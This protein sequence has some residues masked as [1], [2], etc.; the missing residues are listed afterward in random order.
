MRRLSNCSTIGWL[1]KILNSNFDVFD[2]GLL[3]IFQN[4]VI[5]SLIFNFFFSVVSS[6]G[7]YL[8]VMLLLG[9]SLGVVCLYFDGSWENIEIFSDVDVSFA[10]GIEIT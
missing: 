5:S 8:K 1:P 9:L 7:C 3:L 10:S 2:K 4:S 6:L